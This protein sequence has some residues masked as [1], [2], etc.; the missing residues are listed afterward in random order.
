MKHLILALLASTSLPLLACQ[1][2]GQA[3]TAPAS[4]PVTLAISGMT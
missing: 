4:A 2:T 1:N 3:Q